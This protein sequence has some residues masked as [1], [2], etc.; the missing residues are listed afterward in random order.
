M[1]GLLPVATL[2]PSTPFRDESSRVSLIQETVIDLKIAEVAGG[3]GEIIDQER[4]L[5][6]DPRAGRGELKAVQSGRPGPD[7]AGQSG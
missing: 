4:E 6:G 1:C 5:G 7:T 2:T 3:R